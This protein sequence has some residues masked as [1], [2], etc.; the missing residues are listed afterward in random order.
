[1]LRSKPIP[2]LDQIMLGLLT[3]EEASRRVDNW[4]E[5]P[6]ESSATAA[7]AGWRRAC[8]ACLLIF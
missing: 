1:V 4:V 6:E 3:D 2:L 8:E 7:D 5:R